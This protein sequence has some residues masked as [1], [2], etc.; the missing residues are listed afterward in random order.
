ML[1]LCLAWGTELAS[2]RNQ[3]GSSFDNYSDLSNDIYDIYYISHLS[4]AIGLLTRDLNLVEPLAIAAFPDKDIFRSIEDVP[5]QYCTC[6][7][8]VTK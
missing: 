6:K 5:S 3:S 1:R 4:Q 2:K 8:V 7:Q